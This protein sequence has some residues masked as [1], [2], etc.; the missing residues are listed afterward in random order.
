HFKW[1]LSLKE[2][3]NDDKRCQE[4][5]LKASGNKG[6][7]VV[8]EFSNDWLKSVQERDKDGK[9]TAKSTTAKVNKDC[10]SIEI[11]LLKK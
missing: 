1:L 8:N 10:S 11:E 5:L 6:A 7:L 9:H 3:S 4:D 2:K